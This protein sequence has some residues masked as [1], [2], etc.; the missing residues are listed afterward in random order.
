[1][2]TGELVVILVIG[3]GIIGFAL[4]NIVDIISID[5]NAAE[6]RKKAKQQESKSND[7]WDYI[8]D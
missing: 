2:S 7:Y 1:M 8:D 3:F 4:K 5:I 6:A